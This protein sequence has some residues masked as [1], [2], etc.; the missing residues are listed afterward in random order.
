ML[1]K[2]VLLLLILI[3]RPSCE[4]RLPSRTLQ[5]SSSCTHGEKGTSP[6]WLLGGNLLRVLFLPQVLGNPGLPSL[7]QGNCTFLRDLFLITISVP[8]FK[9]VTNLLCC[10]F[11][12]NFRCHEMFL[13]QLLFPYL[14]TPILSST[15]SFDS[16]V[17]LQPLSCKYAS[18]FVFSSL[19]PGKTP[20]QVEHKSLPSLYL[21]PVD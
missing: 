14:P 3:Q 13:S 2:A 12:H 15:P 21:C 16:I 11:Y 18:S 19:P 7:K 9:S 6:T 10:P 20:V 8:L 4:P 5:I 17:K 1:I